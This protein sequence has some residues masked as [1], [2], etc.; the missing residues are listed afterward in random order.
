YTAR[1]HGNHNPQHGGQFFMASDNWHHV[2]GVFSRGAFQLYV[3]DDYSRPLTIEQLRRVKGRVTT[4]H[5]DAPL[6]VARGGRFLE[7]RTGIASNADITAKVRFTPAAPEQRFDFTFGGQGS[8]PAT[9]VGTG[10][11]PP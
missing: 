11:P 7:A 3:Y 4:G 1:P 5:A 10:T 8:L 2:E 9:G 6:T